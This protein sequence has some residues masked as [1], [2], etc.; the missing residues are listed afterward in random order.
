[1]PHK[2]SSRGPDQTDRL[3]RFDGFFVRDRLLVTDVTRRVLDEATTLRARFGFKTAD[4]IHLATAVLHEA[5]VFLT[6]D[7]VFQR[8]VDLRVVVI[9]PDAT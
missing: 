2:A 5:D 7:E 9:D 1:M 4:A 3:A 8:F 6:A